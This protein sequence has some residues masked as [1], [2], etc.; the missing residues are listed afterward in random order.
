MIHDKAVT[1]QLSEVTALEVPKVALH[2][3]N[4]AVVLMLAGQ[5]MIGS[6]SSL[7][8]MVN[9]HEEVLPDASVDVN[10]LVVVPTGN[11]EPETKPAV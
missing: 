8:V 4:A 6:S 5:L 2:K 9:E 10:V 11:T 7:M 1:E 3:P